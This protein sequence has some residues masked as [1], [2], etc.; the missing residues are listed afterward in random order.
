MKIRVRQE[1][2]LIGHIQ[3]GETNC[4]VATWPHT[5]NRGEGDMA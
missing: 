2:T 4:I 3:Y 1:Y 5:L